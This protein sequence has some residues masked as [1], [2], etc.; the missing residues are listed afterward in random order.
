MPF[1]LAAAD[2]FEPRNQPPVD[3]GLKRFWWFTFAIE[4]QSTRQEPSASRR[5]KPV[6]L[7]NFK[8]AHHSAENKIPCLFAVADDYIAVYGYLCD[9]VDLDSKIGRVYVEETA[10]DF[11]VL[12]LNAYLDPVRPFEPFDWQ[13]G[14]FKRIVR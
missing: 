5:D 4:E 14:L 2:P 10:P 8:Q 12:V 7:L 3:D 9:L 11:G 13:I 6:R 1:F